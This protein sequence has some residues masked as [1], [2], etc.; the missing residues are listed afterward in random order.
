PKEQY[1]AIPEGAHRAPLAALA[2][3]A[4]KPALSGR[5]HNLHAKGAI[6]EGAHRAPSAALAALALKS[7]L[8]GG[9]ILY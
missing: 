3:V 1:P 7:A 4:L 5:T 9:I 6:P 8:S 2:A